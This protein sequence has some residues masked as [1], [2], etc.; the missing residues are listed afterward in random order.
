M[1]E[2]SWEFLEDFKKSY[3]KF[4]LEDKLFIQEG[5]NVVDAFIGK[6]YSRKQQQ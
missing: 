1:E 5:S 4:E 2:A 6:K 3:P